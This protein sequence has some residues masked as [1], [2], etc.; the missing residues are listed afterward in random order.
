MRVPLG[1]SATG[2]PVLCFGEAL[3]DSLPA[4]L[5]PGGAP[6]NVAYH[7]ARCGGAAAPVTAVGDDVLGREL[8]ERMRLGGVDTRWVAVLP[9]RA[10]GVARADLAPDGS[11]R[12]SF[13]T[14]A[15]WDCIPV[16]PALEELAAAA[17]AIIHGTL[18]LRGP[19]NRDAL[20]AL[21]AAAPRACRVYDV[22]L[23]PPYD[24]PVQV[25]ALAAGACLLKL[26]LDELRR[27]GD[28]GGEP[29]AAAR[30][31]GRQARCP[32]VCVTAGAAGAGL[33][34]DGAWYW[35][36]GRSVPVRDTVGAGDAFLA[37]LVQRLLVQRHAPAAALRDACRL[38]EHVV[39]RAGAT[40]PYGLRPD[41]AADDKVH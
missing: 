35:E 19:H 33:L 30:S 14:E 28:A 9:G 17:P 31:L 15:A 2:A 27:V 23:R 12:Y 26:N 13:G 39:G 10:T 36:N 18:A 25:R 16:P 5:F 40:P 24:D 29:E 22:N 20:S 38:A 6:F 21:L 32:A 1:G 37:R 3:W 11:A 41:G 4:G 7:L 8:L 34:W